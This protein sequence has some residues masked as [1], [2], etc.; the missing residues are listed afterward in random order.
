MVT[1]T[2]TVTG[3]AASVIDQMTFYGNTVEGQL[4]NMAKRLRLAAPIGS[5][6]AGDSITNANVRNAL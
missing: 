6:R 2:S 3:I 5:L 4:P 1:N